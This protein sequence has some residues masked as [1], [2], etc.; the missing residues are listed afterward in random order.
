MTYFKIAKD[1]T[2]IDANINFL[3]WNSK[4]RC[5]FVCDVSEAEFA[6]SY[7]QTTI[8]HDNWLKPVPSAVTQ[9]EVATV[10]VISATEYDEIRAMLDDGE[11]IPD[12]PDEPPVEPDDGQQ[13]DDSDD[14]EDRPMTVAEMRQII[15]EQQ[16]QIAMLTD[17]ILEMSEVVYGE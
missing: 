16:E 1:G 10:A 13:D 12:V 15:T 17:C 8:Y 5:M 2:V 7:D 14:G 6:Q 11:T 4:H 3:K 9:Y